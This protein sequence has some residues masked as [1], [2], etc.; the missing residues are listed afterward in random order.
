MLTVERLKELVTYDPSTGT[1]VWNSTGKGRRKDKTAGKPD[2][3]G[4]L[5][6]CIDG[7]RYRVHRLAF[8]YMTG[9]WPQGEVDHINGVRT[10]NRW[11][12]LR[13]ASRTQQGRNMKKFNTNTSGVVGVHWVKPR[14]LWSARIVVN[15]ECKVLKDTPDFFEA[16]CAR[17]AAENR[18]GFHP[19]HGR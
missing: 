16:C 9:E 19:N 10:D 11:A 4:Y 14:R 17:K 15:Y 12:N 6:L 3:G 2:S 5:R 8:L 7:S 18:Y 1:L 13:R